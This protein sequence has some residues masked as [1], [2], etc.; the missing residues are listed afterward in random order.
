[1]GNLYTRGKRHVSRKVHYKEFELNVL[2]SVTDE[3][4]I[5]RIAGDEFTVQV[6]SSD[7]F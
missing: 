1:M 2:L 3:Q 6:I 4:A 7:E 5:V